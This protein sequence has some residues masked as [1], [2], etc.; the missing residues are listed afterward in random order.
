MFTPTT[1][2]QVADSCV[3]SENEGQCK[4]AYQHKQ[5]EQLAVER[6][7]QLIHL[8]SQRFAYG[9]QRMKKSEDQNNAHES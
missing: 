6:S 5:N 4:V 9:G 2:S 3:Q 1:E 8:K 7:G